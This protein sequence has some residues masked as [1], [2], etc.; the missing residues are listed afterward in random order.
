[1]KSTIENLIKAEQGMNLVV[2]DLRETYSKSEPLVEIIVMPL[3][4]DAVELEKRL[5]A[6]NRALSDENTS[7]K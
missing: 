5:K 2:S 4:K 1:M 6:L 3:L 7:D